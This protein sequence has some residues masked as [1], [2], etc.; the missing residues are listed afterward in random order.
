M[1]NNGIFNEDGDFDSSTLIQ[2]N[3][4]YTNFLPSIHLKYNL[5]R[6]TVFRFA[7]TNTLARPDYVDLVPFRNIINEDEELELGNPTLEP[8]T[9][10]NFD[11]M[12][13]YYFDNV[14]II[15]GGLFYKDIKDFIYVSQTIASDDALGSGTTGYNVFQPL[16]GDAADVF[17][18]ELAFQRQLDLKQTL[19][20]VKY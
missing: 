18:F 14:G 8:T 19:N 1:K 12:A 13:E 7:W 4:S 5:N 9:A 16:N 15:S 6:K 10:M 3:N 11:L 2:D 17:G 20:L